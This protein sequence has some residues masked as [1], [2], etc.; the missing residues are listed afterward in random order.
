MKRVLFIII[1]VFLVSGQV[2]CRKHIPFID[3]D[4]PLHE[5]EGTGKMYAKTEGAIRFVQYNVGVFH[6]YMTD[7]SPVVAAILKDL[8]ADCVGLNELDCYNK[9]HNTYQMKDF[10]EQQ[11]GPEWEWH[12]QMSINYKDGTYGNGV[13]TRLGP[14]TGRWGQLLPVDPGSEPRSMCVIETA[15]FVA[16]SA[17]IDNTTASSAVM[18]IAGLNEYVTARYGT[19]DKLV[20]LMSDTNTRKGTDAMNEMQKCWTIAGTDGR[21]DYV[22][23]LNNGAK[24]RVVSS[25]SVTRSDAGDVSVASDHKPVFADIVKL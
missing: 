18:A 2:S 20:V 4:H 17:H 14:V 7:S 8:E 23:V 16:I 6:K 19:S 12:Y 13:M 1:G 15:D 5:K 10:A 9:R 22:L 21:F 11:M 24:Y 25:A 3:A